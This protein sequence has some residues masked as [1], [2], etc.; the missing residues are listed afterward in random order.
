MSGP[1]GMHWTDSNHSNNMMTG[2][3]SWIFGYEPKSKHLSQEWHH[4]KLA[5]FKEDQDQ[6]NVDF[7]F[8]WTRN[9]KPRHGQWTRVYASRTS[10]QSAA[11]VWMLQD[12][13]EGMFVWAYILLKAGC[14]MLHQYKMPCHSVFRTLHVQY[15]HV[16]FFCDILKGYLKRCP[17]GTVGTIW[18]TLSGQT[19]S[20]AAHW[21]PVL[22]PEP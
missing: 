16:T 7:L 12:I 13:Q 9:N 10:C 15:S 8:Q 3:E 11:P 17:P 6:N 1:S 2:A 4:L 5:I 21:L 18:R 19:E 22:L 20:N 14:G